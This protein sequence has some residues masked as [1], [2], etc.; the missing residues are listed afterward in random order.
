MLCEHGG[1][2]LVLVQ[3]SSDRVR[4]LELAA[5]DAGVSAEWLCVGL[6]SPSSLMRRS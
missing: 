4:T 3:R 1:A 2:L 5:I 6:R